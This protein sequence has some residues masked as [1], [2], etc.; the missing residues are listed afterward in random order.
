M[1][2][3]NEHEW[4][5]IPD[6]AE[7]LDLPLSKVRR[8]LEERQLLAV[9]IDGVLKVPAEFLRDD[10]PM[11]E[12]RGTIIVL[13][14]NGFNDQE[15]ID[16]LLSVD[17]VLGARPVDALRAGRKAEVRRVAQALA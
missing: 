16:W 5:T 4:L 9:R 6:L 2:A 15:A 12:L 10:E 8:L 3:P 1:A 17:E 7:R 14:D 13:A 11:N